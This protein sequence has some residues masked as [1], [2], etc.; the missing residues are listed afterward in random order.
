MCRGRK[1]Q[2]CMQPTRSLP[3]PSCNIAC[4]S[5]Y[6]GVQTSSTTL[7]CLLHVAHRPSICLCYCYTPT[8]TPRSIH[9]CGLAAPSSTQPQTNCLVLLLHIR[10]SV[11][12]V[13]CR[14]SNRHTRRSTNLPLLTN[15][16]MSCSQAS[17]SFFSTKALGIDI[18][19]IS[20]SYNC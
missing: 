13:A 8:P 19:Y 14:F 10:P 7:L 3:N 15:R 4:S 18:Y 2:A 16:A 1:E 5:Y 9:R 17:P 11:S 12:A 20:I 6:I